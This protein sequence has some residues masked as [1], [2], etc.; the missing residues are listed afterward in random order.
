ML[1]LFL[2]DDRKIITST[3]THISFRVDNDALREPT[4]LSEI[5]VGGRFGCCHRLE[6]RTSFGV[7]K[8]IE[9]GFLLP[10]ETVKVNACRQC[11]PQMLAPGVLSGKSLLNGLPY[12][13]K[14]LECLQHFWAT[15]R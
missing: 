1:R 11:K 7:D 9:F 3:F 13:F 12:V 5:V 2:L 4:S 6:G 8:C 10:S 15:F 14:I